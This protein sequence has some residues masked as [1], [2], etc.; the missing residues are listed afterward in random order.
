MLLENQAEFFAGA[1][2]AYIE[3]V[4]GLA[5][6][7]GVFFVAFAGK[8]A[9]VHPIH[10]DGVEFS[11]LRAV[12]RAQAHSTGSLDMAGQMG[13]RNIE[14]VGRVGVGDHL[15]AD[16]PLLLGVSCDQTPRRNQLAV[17]ALQ[18]VVRA[19]A[20]TVDSASN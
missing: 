8:I 10:H 13:K 2:D 14:V 9:R 1:C 4:A 15:G 3:K 12:Q 17:K 7:G 16:I 6:S 20:R 19:I 11:S 18:P 5:K